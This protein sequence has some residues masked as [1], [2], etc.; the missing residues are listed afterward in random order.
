MLVFVRMKHLDLALR[1]VIIHK[2]DG[3]SLTYGAGKEL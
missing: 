2:D 3:F 1:V